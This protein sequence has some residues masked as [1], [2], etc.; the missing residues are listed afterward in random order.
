MALDS[1]KNIYV[2]GY[3]NSTSFPTTTGVYQKTNLSGGQTAFVAKINPTL[4]GAASLVY[5]TYL[6]G[7]TTA[8]TENAIAVDGTDNAYVVGNAGSDF[9]TTAGAYAYDGEDVGYGGVFVTKLN[10]TATALVYSAYLGYGNTNGIGGIAVDGSGDA[11]VT[12][13]AGVED[14]PTTAGAYQLTY[15]SGFASELNAAGSAL[16]YSTFL[17]GALELTYPTDIAIEPGCASAC[18]AF[19]TGYTGEDDL[20]VTLPIQSFNATWVNG[21]E[22]DNVFVTELNATGTAAVYSTYVGGS[23]SDSTA[24]S[25]HSPAVAVDASGDA[26]VVGQTSSTNFPVTLTATPYRSAFA[27]EIGATAAATAVVY[28]LTLALPTNQP[29]GVPS[30]PMV[31][32]LQNLGSNAM[33]I[34]SITPS[35]ASYTE[36]NTCGTSLAGGGECAITVTF[37]PATATSIPGTLTIVQGGNNSPNKVTLTGTGVSQP[38]LTLS[39]TSLTF[40]NQPVD[41]ASPYQTVTIGNSAPTSLT[42]SS[43][44]FTVYGNFAQTNNCPAALAHNATCTVNIAFLPTEN[45][46][47]T[48]QLYVNS[49]TSS[50]VPF[51]YVALSGNGVVGTPTLT[52]NAAG[53]VFNAQDVG[54]LSTAQSV[55]VTNTGNVPVSIFGSSITG[56]AYTDYTATNCFNT[57]LNPGGTCPIRVTFDPTTTGTRAA[58]ITMADSTTVGTHSFTVTGTG[59]APTLTLSITPPT[60]PFAALGV[61][62]TSTAFPVQVTNTGDASVVIERVYATGDFRLNSTGCVTTVRAGYGCTTQ[63][64]FTPLAAG[65][66]TG[67]L[68]FE[69]SATGSPQSVAL[70]GTGLVAAAAAITTPDSLDFGTQANGTT[71][72]TA[73]T[74]ILD[75]V[76]NVPLDISKVSL[77]GTDPGDF[78]ISYQGCLA[79][80]VVPGRNCEVQ[81]TFT[82]VAAG[83]RG[84]ATLNFTDA[85]GTQTVN[86]TG[87]GVAATEALN[88][89]PTALTFEAQQKG[90]QSPYQSVW[91]INTGTAAVTP[92][93]IVSA[94]TDYEVSGCVGT[95]IQ[96]NTSCELYVYFTPTV[97]TADNSTLKVTS[98]AT[99]SPQT[100]TLTG[101]GAAAA[102]V[103]ELAPSGLAFTSQVVSTASAAQYVEVTNTSAAAVAGITIATAGTNAAYFTI[104]SNSCAATLAAATSCSFYVSFKPTAAGE[105]TASVSVKYTGGSESV[106]LAGFGVAA[107]TSALLLESALEFPSETIG[108]TSPSQAPAVFEN[109]GNSPLTISSIVLGGSNPGDFT[110]SSCSITN[111]LAAGL[112][113]NINVTFTPT[114]AGARSA[115]VT[116]TYTGATGSPAVITLSGMGVAASQ[117][118]A[119]GP[120]TI[121]FPPQ[122]LTTTSTLSPYVLL[123]NTGTSP[124]TISSVALTGDSDFTISSQGCPI[125]PST[126]QQGPIS[127]TC[128]VY[129]SFTPTVAGARTATV[130][131]TDSAPS[132]PTKITLNG[133]GVAETK[134]L[135]V[136]PTTL[137]FGPQVSA[138]TSSTLQYITV[139][140]TGNFTVTFTNVTITGNYALASQGCTGQIAP[141]SSCSIGVSFTPTSAGAKT[142]TVTI[143]DNATVATQKVTLS[144][145]GI[146]TTSDILLSQTAV[147]FDAQTVSTA[148]S[149]QV[150]YY[151]N[152]GNTTS[153]IASTVLAGTNPG[154]FSLSG[155]SCT[156]S[157]AV[158]TLTYCTLRITFTPAAAGARSATLTV[159]DSDPGSPRVINLS[160]TG[161]SSSV[162]E[163]GLYPASLTFASTAEGSSSAAQNITLTN[164]G[165]AKLTIS[166][167]GITFTGTDPGDYSETNNCPISPATLAAGF[168]CNIAITFS[169]KGTGAR[170]ANLTVADSATSSPQSATLTGTGVAGA[171]GVATPS[172]TSLAFGNVALGTPSEL[173]ITVKNTGTAAL[174]FASPSVAITGTV[175]SDFSQTNTCT[176]SL[177]PAATCT[178]KVTFTPTTI[179]SQTGTVT[180]TDNATNS[181][182]AVPIT[183]T[184]AEAAVDLSPSALAFPSTVEGTTSAPL[185]VT[186][187]NY[188]DANLTPITVSVAA[189]FVISANKCVAPLAPGLTCTI[190]IEFSPK[191]AGAFAG[192][193]TII[194]N[195]GDSPQQIELSGTGTS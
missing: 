63:V 76:G 192:A 68:I 12:G 106:A 183:G 194:D 15:P 3:T 178:I 113:C 149:P 80:I 129:L 112:N 10:P 99:G 169:P 56:T 77:A 90:V 177:A 184:G 49:N 24:Y 45:G 95:A 173:P 142:G 182:Q 55:S 74:V 159:A 162:P 2:T 195:A 14:F 175:S 187:E 73:L 22:N 172:P 150:V 59:V 92:S 43:P 29:V 101:T 85:A 32:T 51:T 70:T 140:N 19:I 96:P 66:L 30:A 109:T 91:L 115:T 144:G 4:S 110:M 17:G 120:A 191:A 130:T 126:L 7:P 161:I 35:P 171:V 122:V 75:N 25:A 40:D 79:T 135:T 38:F 21:A 119:V 104:S 193:V 27:L 81:V 176:G 158:G 124:V 31:V 71:T 83:A 188:G 88:L 127:N 139:T 121:T 20:S 87:T 41:T 105:A 137:A 5:S 93:A 61:G 54:T 145:T 160:G 28:P 8:S 152:Q 179:E 57:N 9:P 143:T 23:T 72:P 67:S 189:P 44:A 117:S 52:L 53:L 48:G 13:T 141:G 125:S 108:F 102:A 100:I 39:P 168:S 190:S 136:T 128:A 114:V 185:T 181:P 167:T 156:A 34:T 154:D 42:L 11:Y 133:N 180:I 98:N 65:A 118:L 33:P 47:F 94:S 146:A 123:T 50:L 82:P 16:V 18:D 6:S 97:T 155:S 153:T 58:T 147:V 111:P 78:Q 103:M 84:P 138:T 148:S 62:G 170:P 186:V 86:L 64:E 69:D 1:A 163:V 131:V 116:I 164:N 157:T 166:S 46:S 37:T 89:T 151:Y 134:V 174:T 165:S 132:S 60:V 26:Y 107:T 36:T